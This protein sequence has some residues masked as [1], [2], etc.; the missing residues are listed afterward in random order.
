MFPTLATSHLRIQPIKL[1]CLVPDPDPLRQELDAA[2]VADLVESFQTLGRGPLHPLLVKP[3]GQGRY[4]I[5][6]GHHRYEALKASNFKEAPCLVLTPASDEA[7]FLLKLHANTKRKN[8]PDLEACEALVRER[9]I[10]EAVYPETKHGANRGAPCGQFGHTVNK[11]FVSLKAKSL[12]AGTRTIRRDI[13]VGECVKRFPELKSIGAK[14]TDVCRLL[15]YP[16]IVQ[17]EL[18]RAMQAAQEPESVLRF[19]LLQAKK[20]RYKRPFETP[21]PLKI[22]LEQ[23][24]AI[25]EYL[26]Q[27]IDWEVVY[28]PQRLYLVEEVFQ[29]LAHHAQ[30]EYHRVSELAHRRMNPP[31]SDEYRY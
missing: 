25:I 30:R 2:H 14:K 31:E 16:P 8:L 13:K 26:K 5:L 27:G 6:S 11:S 18:R 7:E 4:Q 21:P 22:D 12:G 9:D 10:Y 15:Q 19:Y 24:K 29:T 28:S 17:E 3:L 20:P 1:D 23:F